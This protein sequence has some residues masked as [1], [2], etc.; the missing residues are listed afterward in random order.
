MILQAVR[1]RVA[2]ALVPDHKRPP[3]P[4]GLR[5]DLPQEVAL[6]VPVVAVGAAEGAEVDEAALPPGSERRSKRMMRAR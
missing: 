1:V 6:A 3:A 4:A 5:A 2:K